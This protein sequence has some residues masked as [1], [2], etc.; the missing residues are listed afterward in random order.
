MESVYEYPLL[1][2]DSTPVVLRRYYNGKAVLKKKSLKHLLIRKPKK[3]QLAQ[4]PV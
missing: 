4:A 1:L 3:Y 2:Q